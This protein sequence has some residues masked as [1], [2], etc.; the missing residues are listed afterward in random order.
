MNWNLPGVVRELAQDRLVVALLQRRDNLREACLALQASGQVQ[1]LA[2]RLQCRLGSCHDLC[3]IVRSARA[4]K[5]IALT[6]ERAMHLICVHVH[7]KPEFREA[8]MFAF[9]I[10]ILL[11]GV[12]RI[13][14]IA[15]ELG[16]GIREFRSGLSGQDEESPAQGEETEPKQLKD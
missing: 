10:I 2:A 4:A 15:G 5:K 14:K 3:V 1:E 16:K 7:V 6:W 13:G 8:F 12:G 9:V 11:F